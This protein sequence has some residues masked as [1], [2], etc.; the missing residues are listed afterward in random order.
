MMQVIEMALWVVV[1]VVLLMMMMSYEVMTKIC[2]CFEVG[3][4][5][6]EVGV[7]VRDHHILVSMAMSVPAAVVAVVVVALMEW[8]VGMIHV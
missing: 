3:V 4:R 1:M 2:P 5:V 8:T 6:R 7:E